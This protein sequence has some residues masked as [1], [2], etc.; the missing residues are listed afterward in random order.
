M[1]H[2]LHEKFTSAPTETSRTQPSLEL[3]TLPYCPTTYKWET[4]PQSGERA[5]CL[6]SLHSLLQKPGFVFARPLPHSSSAW[7]G[8]ASC[9][10]LGV[11]SHLPSPTTTVV[12]QA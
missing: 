2:K 3:Y 5:L 12:S 7:S 11:M 1:S 4:E 6:P 10:G 9:P 8:G